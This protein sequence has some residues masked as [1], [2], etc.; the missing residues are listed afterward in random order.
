MV[1]GWLRRIRIWRRQVWEGSRSR[2]RRLI[3]PVGDLGTAARV[4]EQRKDR[5]HDVVVRR[6]TAA[7]LMGASIA[8][9]MFDLK[10]RAGLRVGLGGVDNK[11]I[12]EYELRQRVAAGFVSWPVGAAVEAVPEGKVGVQPRAIGSLVGLGQ[13]E[14]ILHVVEVADLEV[15]VHDVELF[16]REHEVLHLRAADTLESDW[17]LAPRQRLRHHS[18]GAFS[19]EQLSAVDLND[20]AQPVLAV[21]KDRAG[22]RER[23]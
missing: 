22:I 8:G 10:E 19:A 13:V 6:S 16:R 18:E 17:E 7:R 21:E 23:E 5:V 14:R 4:D 3:H 20:E 11:I 1:V 15:A 2:H 9:S 12:R